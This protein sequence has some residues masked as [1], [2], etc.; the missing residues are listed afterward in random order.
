MVYKQLV[1]LQLLFSS[2]KLKSMQSHNLT[3]TMK[4]NHMT[5]P[6]LTPKQYDG[7]FDK[8]K[9]CEA[10]KVIQEVVHHSLL[11]LCSMDAL[12]H[13]TSMCKQLHLGLKVHKH[14]SLN[15]HKEV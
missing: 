9:V 13:L 14:R 8:Y 15:E 4:K 2:R 1:T 5:V 6:H 7:F 12:Q 10:E 3:Q 11:F